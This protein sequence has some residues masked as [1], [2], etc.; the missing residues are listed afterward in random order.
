MDSGFSNVLVVID[1]PKDRRV[2]RL[3]VEENESV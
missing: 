2:S 3:M 1:S